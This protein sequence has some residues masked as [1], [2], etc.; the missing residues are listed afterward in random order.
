MVDHVFVLQR[1]FSQHFKPL[2][3][4]D[5]TSQKLR[6]CILLKQ[7][8]L[9]SVKELPFVKGM[10]QVGL[11]VLLPVRYEVKPVANN[12]AELNKSSPPIK[13]LRLQVVVCA[14]PVLYTSYAAG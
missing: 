10:A 1:A 9:V 11:A 5:G 14:I 8:L 13:H 4:L 2:G 3:S 7:V 6:S 12:F